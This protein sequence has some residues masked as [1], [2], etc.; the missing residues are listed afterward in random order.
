MTATAKSFLRLLLLTL[1]IGAVLFYLMMYHLFIAMVLGGCLM[2]FVCGAILYINIKPLLSTLAERAED[3][4]AV[5]PDASGQ[6]LHI[7]SSFSVTRIKLGMSPLRTIQ[8]YFLVIDTRKLYYKVLFTHDMAAAEDHA[9]YVDYSSFEEDVLEGE[10]FKVALDAYSQKA[11]WPLRLGKAVA[12]GE[13]ESY[14]TKLDGYIFKIE[15]NT[16]MIQDT[17]RLCCYNADGKLEWRKKI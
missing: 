3:I 8:Y 2:L 1:A 5:Y 12:E 17:L 7:F 9:G 6:G 4:M 10:D 16:Q 11:G 13:D 14:E 15:R